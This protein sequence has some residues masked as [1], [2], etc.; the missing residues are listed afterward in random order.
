MF[1]GKWLRLP[2]IL[3]LAYLM[4]RSLTLESLLIALIVVLLMEPV[5]RDD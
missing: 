2:M 4:W 1:F 5:T 3:G